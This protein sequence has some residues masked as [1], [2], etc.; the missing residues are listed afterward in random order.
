MCDTA[1]RAN[2]DAHNFPADW[3]FHHRWGRNADAVTTRGEKIIHETIG[4]RTT[5][6]VP[7][8]QR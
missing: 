3:L 5:A 1:C 8:V 7:V 4:G 2:A 6:W